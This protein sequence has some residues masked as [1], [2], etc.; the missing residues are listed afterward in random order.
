MP[1]TR[2][3]FNIVLFYVAHRESFRFVCSCV[4]STLF[5]RNGTKF[6]A[7]FLLRVGS[8]ISTF[9]RGNAGK[10]RQ[11]IT[12]MRVH[13]CDGFSAVCSGGRAV[14]SSLCELLKPT[15]LSL[16]DSISFLFAHS[17]FIPAAKLIPISF[18]SRRASL[19]RCAARVIIHV[20]PCG[21]EYPRFP[22]YLRPG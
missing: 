12:R 11:F 15:V 10:R 1:F 19:S 21:I 2:V 3:I 13:F 20:I 4:W 7:S 14:R 5:T 16:N 6:I 22:R 8:H 18:F 17:S 9:F